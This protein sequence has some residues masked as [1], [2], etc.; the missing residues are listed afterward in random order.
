MDSPRI[1]DPELISQS[2]DAAYDNELIP[3]ESVGDMI[4]QMDE[5]T[6]AQVSS[7]GDFLPRLQ[8]FGGN[9]DAC[10]K[11]QIQIAHY[12]LVTGK[13]TIEDLG[14]EVDVI[15]ICGRPK[16]L[17]I[18]DDG[19]IITKFDP[20][21]DQF[22]KIAE[23]SA[24]QDSGCMYGPEFMLFIP[25]TQRFATFFM[26]SKTARRS[27]ASVHARLRK[28]AT[29]KAEFIET[30][31]YSWHGPVCVPCSTPLS[32]PSADDIKAAVTK[33][34]SAKE[35]SVEVAKP[36]EAGTEARAR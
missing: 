5:K 31:K 18:C 14:K 3:V 25:D 20:N 28:A 10:K 9:S 33:F 32:P 16:A 29:L 24:V 2:Q 17:R 23:D 27:A 6:L 34:M 4:P 7:S 1:D 19:T 35:S 11:G 8:L 36:A 26:S 21:D 12:G 30:K 15:V 13:D 22:K